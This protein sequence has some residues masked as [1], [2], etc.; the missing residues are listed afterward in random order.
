[1]DVGATLQIANLQLPEG[2][3]AAYDSNYA[4]VSVLMPG[5]GDSGDDGSA[6]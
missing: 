1:M 3:T 6:E 2:V 4:I 5:S